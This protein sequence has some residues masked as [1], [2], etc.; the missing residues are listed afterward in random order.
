MRP[1]RLNRLGSIDGLDLVEAPAPEPAPGQVLARI[2]AVSLNCR[3]YITVLGLYAG[4]ARSELVPLS[5]GPG[6]VAALG[7]GAT[8]FEVG[9]RVCP[10]FCPDWIAG[11]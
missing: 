11:P 3:D 7:P 9:H 4:P 2:R 8:R 5:D 10:I 6:E 1:Y